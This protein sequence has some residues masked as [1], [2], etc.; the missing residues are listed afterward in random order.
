M[1]G[2][3]LG[4]EVP[5]AVVRLALRQLAEVHLLVGVLPSKVQEPRQSRRVLLRR[6]AIAGGVALPTLAPISAPS[7]V[8]ATSHCIRRGQGDCRQTG[9]SC[10]TRLTCQ[11][12]GK[13][14]GGTAAL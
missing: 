10:C 9:T 7:A 2:A 12:D 1:V 5:E 14:T 8:A 11:P 4:V 13:C 3:G 6:M